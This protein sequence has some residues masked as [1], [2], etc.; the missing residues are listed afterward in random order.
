MKFKQFLSITL[1]LLI[2]NTNL[3]SASLELSSLPPANGT[4]KGSSTPE[5]PEQKSK[6]IAKNAGKQEDEPIRLPMINPFHHLF[7]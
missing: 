1:V 6:P 2:I 7:R 5:K 4:V 3:Q